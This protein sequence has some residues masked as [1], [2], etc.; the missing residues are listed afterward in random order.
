[1]MNI[2]PPASVDWAGTF[3]PQNLPIY[4]YYDW[5]KYSSYT[6]GVG[7][8]FTLQ[9]TDDFD[10][11]NTSRWAKATHTFDGNN[12]DFIPNNAVFQDG[13]MILCLTTPTEVGYSGAPVPDQD[14]DAA[15]I[16]WARSYP[17][18][19]KI[20]FSEEVEKS[21]AETL[22]HYT[23]PGLDLLSATLLSDGRTVL[24]SAENV[25]LTK[26]YNLVVQGVKDL[27]EPANIMELAFTVI[28][29]PVILP[30]RLNVGGP[31]WENY[32]AD[33]S[34]QGVLEYGHVGGQAVTHSPSLEIAGTGEDELFR[35][36][37]RGLSFF[38]IRVKNGLYRV[39]LKFA[40]TEYNSQGMRVF[41]ILAEGNLYASDFDIYQ[42]AGANTATEKILENVLVEDGILD[43]YLKQRSGETALSGIQVE[44]MV[45]ALPRGERKPAHFRWHIYPNPFN[46]STVIFY[47]L[48]RPGPVNIILYDITGRYIDKPVKGFQPAGP[49]RTR[50]DLSGYSTGIYLVQLTVGNLFTETRK[51]LY[52]K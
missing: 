17:G 46:S 5:V 32:L 9:W 51:I 3:D 30:A 33:Q 26:N 50:I 1:M 24:L 16:A 8:N 38:S 37:Q 15:Y 44:E 47:D 31:A 48:P 29:K 23:V 43:I 21:S 42:E 28:K 36:E 14:Q 39:T 22:S 41:H 10:S 13:Y 7:D 25:D 6:P 20:Y 18:Q 35:T 45:T 27:A 34:F 4:A 12:C 2:W 52:T 40:E 11:W 19:I 49:H